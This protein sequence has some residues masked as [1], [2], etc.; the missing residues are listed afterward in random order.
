MLVYVFMNCWLTYLF[1]TQNVFVTGL[2]MPICLST[3]D[4]VTQNLEGNFLSVAGRD[5]AFRTYTNLHDKL[6]Y[7]H[8][9]LK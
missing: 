4:F 8:V 3:E 1:L 6:Y 7:L 5:N 2:I 9:H